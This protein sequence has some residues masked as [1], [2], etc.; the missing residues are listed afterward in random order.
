MRASNGWPQGKEHTKTCR[1]H[2]LKLYVLA[3]VQFLREAILFV[4]V[5]ACFL[6]VAFLLFFALITALILLSVIFLGIVVVGGG[7]ISGPEKV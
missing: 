1:E 4:A 6:P 3:D 2:I 5:H 7:I